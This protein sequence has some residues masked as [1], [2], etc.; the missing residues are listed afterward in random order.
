MFKVVVGCR[1]LVCQVNG[2]KR[3]NKRFVLGY[4]REGNKRNEK[5]IS[6]NKVCTAQRNVHKL[7]DTEKTEE[8]GGG[9]IQ[10]YW[11]IAGPRKHIPNNCS[12][13]QNSV[14]EPLH[15]TLAETH[16]QF[17]EVLWYHFSPK[18]R[19]NTFLGS[20]SGF[21]ETPAKPWVRIRS[22]KVTILLSNWLICSCNAEQS[23]RCPAS[24]SPTFTAFAAAL[25]DA[26]STTA[27]A[28]STLA[29][30]A[31]ICRSSASLC[32]CSTCFAIAARR[33]SEADSI[34]A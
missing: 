18:P 20:K 32:A 12:V 5:E 29:F 22:C 26:A 8:V 10:R 30:S 28:A 16:K 7:E 25:D 15:Q 31:T 19:K 17:S 34:S 33:C 1:V 6:D 24:T 2:K 14:R 11:D 3:G 4:L 21:R 9:Q 23:S 27:A 13:L